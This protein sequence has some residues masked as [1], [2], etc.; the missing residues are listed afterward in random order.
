[1]DTPNLGLT[2][3][4]LSL[5]AL[6]LAGQSLMHLSF[7]ARLT[8]KKQK[9]WLFAVYFPLLCLLEA[10]F[11]RLSLPNILGIAAQALILYALSRLA[12]ANRPAISVIATLFAIYISQLSFGIINSIEAILLPRLVGRPLLYLVLLLATAA[13]LA[14]CAASYAAVLRSFSLAHDSQTPYVGL[15]LFPALFFFI[16]EWYILRTAYSTVALPFR[17]TLIEAGKHAAL[18]LLQTL[19]LAALL[20]TLYAY[21]QLCRSF[22]AQAALQ[23]L[24]QASHAQKTYIAEAQARYEQTKAF[25]HDIK[26]HLAVLDGLL[27][28]GKL[29]E[30]RAY[31]QKLEAVSA[32]LSFPYHTGNPI[33][34]ILLS[35]KL[36][37]AET[38][39]IAAEISLLL[40]TP[41]GIDDLD[42]CVLFANAL[43]N[44]LAACE[45]ANPAPIAGRHGKEANPARIAGGRQEEANAAR[46]AGSR[47]EETKFIRITGDRQ[48]D[49]YLLSFENTCPDTPLPPIGTGLSN[50]RS[51]A[52]KYH[53]AMMA[54]KT[55]TRFSLNVLLDISL[56]TESIPAQTP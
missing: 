5:T 18:L 31:L 26:N 38:N 49:Y 52:E 30:S 46:I 11:T 13:A 7:L 50:I 16:A 33:V 48:G 20:C 39:G 51:V 2:A 56:H 21:R 6:C 42:L 34:D 19:G 37:L 10:L 32:R 55:G 27:Q 23:S 43:D 24:A 40:P 3:F 1:M 45:E 9:R 36:S 12:L 25:R 28:N 54:E 41:C 22:Q 15:L 4:N 44:A 53:G 35:E 47:Q 17:P 29:P 14:L 8:A